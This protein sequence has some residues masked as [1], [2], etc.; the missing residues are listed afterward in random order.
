MAGPK[1]MD[2]LPV[3][4]Q[5]GEAQVVLQFSHLENEV[6]REARAWL[7]GI[8]EVREKTRHI[9]LLDEIKKPH[10]PSF[11]LLVAS[12][13]LATATFVVAIVQ[14]SPAQS[15]AVVVA[16]STQTTPLVRNTPA[17]SPQALPHSVTSQP[18]TT[19]K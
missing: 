3:F 17:S 9:E 16:P 10:K 8:K 7:Y 4:E 5:L 1:Q 12:V 19:K 14:Q 11:Y 2:H 18:S 13:I 15:P 6:G